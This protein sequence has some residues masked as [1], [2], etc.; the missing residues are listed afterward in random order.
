[1][2]KTRILDKPTTKDYNALNPHEEP[3]GNVPE[4]YW[5]E[6]VK[7]TPKKKGGN[8]MVCFCIQLDNQGI[9]ELWDIVQQ[10]AKLFKVD[11][12]DA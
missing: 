11:V 7:P 5:H 6:T 4:K 3:K 1:M 2:V 10:T 8:M 9:E 12:T